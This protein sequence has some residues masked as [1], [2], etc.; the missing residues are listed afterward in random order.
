MPSVVAA[1]AGTG[2][3]PPADSVATHRYAVGRFSCLIV[4]GKI[5][6]HIK[7]APGTGNERYTKELVK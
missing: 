3:K 7:E 6:R 1:G 2:S 4:K 5:L